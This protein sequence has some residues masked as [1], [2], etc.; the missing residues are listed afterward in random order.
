MQRYASGIQRT[1]SRIRRGRV[2][3][4]TLLV[5]TLG[6]A[7]GTDRG[8]AAAQPPPAQEEFVPLEQVIAAHLDDLQL[9]ELDF[10]KL[11]VEGYEYKA[12]QGAAET[13]RNC[14]PMV[15]FE[16]KGKGDDPKLRQ[17][18]EY[19]QSLGARLVVEENETHVGLPGPAENKLTVIIRTP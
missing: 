14:Q 18:H 2:I 13:L 4:V 1:E 17:A 16:D 9:E 3:G 12:L 8:V 19:L 15:M 6:L 11:D 10:M 7:G 5:V